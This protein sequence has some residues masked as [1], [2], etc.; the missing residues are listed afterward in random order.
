MWNVNNKKGSPKQL[1]GHSRTIFNLCYS[2]RDKGKVIS[3][4][5]DRAII[6]WNLN[7]AKQPVELEIPT[8]GGFVYSIDYSELDE[9]KLAIGVG[10]KTIRIW[11]TNSS[12]NAFENLVIWKGIQSMVTLVKWHP[13]IFGLLAFGTDDG[14]IGLLEVYQQKTTLF[15]SSHRGTVYQLEWKLK[16]LD[17]FELEKTPEI[18]EELNE[19]NS[20]K[21]E[22]EHLYALY[23]C[24]GDGIIYKSDPSNLFKKSIDI[25]S[26]I[27]KINSSKQVLFRN[28]F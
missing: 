9:G 11:N 21:S 10:D 20:K 28:Y 4:S 23:S 24:G 8:L 3:F 14:R 13:T 18:E 26:F 22:E 25:T 6:L 5:L 17:R 1:Q 7:Q 19:S 27:S 16:A 12:E 2:P 15:S